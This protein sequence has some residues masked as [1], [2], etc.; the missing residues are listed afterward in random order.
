[1]LPAEMSDAAIAGLRGRTQRTLLRTRQG[2]AT[3]H[4]SGPALSFSSPAKKIVVDC[5]HEPR[6]CYVIQVPIVG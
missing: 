4:A 2:S 1:M 5:G 6:T 3:R